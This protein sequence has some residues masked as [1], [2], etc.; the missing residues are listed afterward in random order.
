MN[1]SI[2]MKKRIFEQK[3]DY[4]LCDSYDALIHF[5]SVGLKK[6]IP[7]ITSS[8]KILSKKY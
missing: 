6:E 4:I 1:V 5:Y 7:V 8:P 2:N 3:Y